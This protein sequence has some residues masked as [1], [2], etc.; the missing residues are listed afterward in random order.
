MN[1]SHRI[2]AAFAIMLTV[3][4]GGCSGG[5]ET[6]EKQDTASVTES[7]GEHDRDGK[8][9]D[10]E[11]RSEHGGGEESGTELALTDTYD[12]VRNGARLILAYN[13]QS[14][15]FNGTVVNVVNVV[16]VVSMV[17]KAE[18]NTEK[19]IPDDTKT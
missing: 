18:A 19:G 13:A 3:I 6:A 10:G 7:R 5:A 12:E 16:N 4:I 1:H 9:H 15:S 8:D 11:G 2:L 17:A 14:N